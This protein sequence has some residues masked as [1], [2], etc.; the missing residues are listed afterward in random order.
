MP[1]PFSF[2]K[3]KYVSTHRINLIFNYLTLF[4]NKIY[5]WRYE[6]FKFMFETWSRRHKFRRRGTG[7]S[8]NKILRVGCTLTSDHMA[9]FWRR[10]YIQ[11]LSIHSCCAPHTPDTTHAMPACSGTAQGSP[12]KDISS[13]YNT[14]HHTKKVLFFNLWCLWVIIIFSFSLSTLSSSSNESATWAP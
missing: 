6:R 9:P 12:I 13:F 4:L 11:S 8:L 1:R 3:K 7:R 14:E 2:V 5:I 10:A